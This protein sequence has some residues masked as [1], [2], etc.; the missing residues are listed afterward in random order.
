MGPKAFEQSAGFLR[1]RDA[2]NPLDTSAVHPE[3]Y[4]VVDAMAQAVSCSLAELIRD[5]AKLDQLDLGLFVKEE[6]GLP[7]LSDIVEELKRPGRDPRKQFEVFSFA[8]DVNK[9][10][11]LKVGMK[12]PG[13]I[14]NVTNFGAFVDVGVHQD[15][16]VHISQ[17]AD[18]FVQDPNDVVKVQQQVRVTVMDVDIVRNRISLSMKAVSEQTTEKGEL[19]PAQRTVPK[20]VVE[21]AK[22]KAKGQAKVEKKPPRSAS[23]LAEALNRAG[24]N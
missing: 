14:T 23:A 5:G 4:V 12:L 22:P 13:I 19:R 24:L 6:L 1:I 15:G 20:K 16:L 17:L 9:I 21:R 7:T 3:R 10:D 8:D 18:K 2:G 11:D